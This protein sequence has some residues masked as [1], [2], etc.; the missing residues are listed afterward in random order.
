MCWRKDGC[1]MD[2]KLLEKLCMVVG[3]SGDEG[4]VKD[5]IL[6][7]VRPYADAIKQTPLGD[8][9]VFVKGEKAADK[10]LMIGAHM[11]EVGMIVTEI[12]SDGYLKFSAVGGIDSNVLLGKTV[13][14]NKTVRG[15]IGGKP[16]HLMKGDEKEKAVPMRELTVDIGAAS[17]E[18][19]EKVCAVG[20]Y[21]SFPPVFSCAGG[22]IQ[23]KALDDRIGCAVLV[24]LIKGG[25]PYDTWFAFTTRE[26]VGCIGATAAAY[27][28]GPDLAIAVEGTVAGDVLGTSG[29]KA[30]TRMGKGP[31][32]SFVDRGTVYDRE[33]FKAAFQCAEA[34]D[35]PCQPRTSNAG[36]NDAAAMHTA[37]GGARVAAVSTPCR[38]I[39]SPVSMAK[40]SDAEGCVKLV[41]ALSKVMMEA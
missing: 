39:H 41:K 38:Y 15:V 2:L 29:A 7:E 40:L 16:V 17:R 10:T 30:T 8:L 26:E 25:M 32:V 1:D 37:R 24:A 14:V 36:S 3:I 33:F 13:Y 31:A 19:A 11:D 23:G 21:I 34:L 18:E 12:T 6:E 4:D 28:I 22:I 35:I 5:I 20:D 9:L 27:E